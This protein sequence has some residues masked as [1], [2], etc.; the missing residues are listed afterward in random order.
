MQPIDYTNIPWLT[1]RDD[2]LDLSF[3]YPANWKITTGSYHGDIGLQAGCKYIAEQGFLKNPATCDDTTIQSLSPGLTLTPPIPV[4]APKL[5]SEQLQFM[6]PTSG[7][8]GGCEPTVCPTTQ[9]SISINGKT[10]TFTTISLPPDPKNYPFNGV[11]Y[12]TLEEAGVSIPTGA[13]SIWS[14]FD[15]NLFASNK[16]TF[17]I[18]LKILNSISY[19]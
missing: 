14:K 5:Y 11:A 3:R 9:H 6:G 4:N 16:Q 12:E 2:I 7:L 1:Y 15:F 8:G 10:Y 13:K 19:H 17:D 18:D